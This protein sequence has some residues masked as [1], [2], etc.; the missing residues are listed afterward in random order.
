LQKSRFLNEFK[1][2]VASLGTYNM[3]A[4]C[5]QYLNRLFEMNWV[6]EMNVY[7]KLIS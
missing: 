7:L 1:K 2:Q 6:F 5:Q 3:T 4:M